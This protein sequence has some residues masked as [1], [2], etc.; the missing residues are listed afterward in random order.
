MLGMS[1]LCWVTHH[2]VILRESIT[3][4][5]MSLE[6]FNHRKS[7]VNL[8]LSRLGDLQ[9]RLTSAYFNFLPVKLMQKKL[10]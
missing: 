4:S 9:V 1:A 5:V 2:K 6:L 7:A 8:T 10:L 3:I